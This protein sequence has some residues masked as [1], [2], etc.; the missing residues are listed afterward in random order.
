MKNALIATD[1][2]GEIF[3][4]NF[5]EAPFY[6][7]YNRDNFLKR[8]SNKNLSGI[9]LSQYILMGT[10]VSDKYREELV[11]SGVDSIVLDFKNLNS[12]RAFYLDFLE[13]V[14]VFE[15]YSSEYEFWF[16]ENKFVYLSE[17]EALKM[18]VPSEGKGLEVGVGSGRF[19]KPL[20]ILYGVEP[21][22]KMAQ[23]AR[24]R[25]IKVY[26]GLAEDL[27][28]R[29]SEFDFV[30]LA[31]TICFVNDPERSLLEAKRVLK[32]GSKLIVAIVD[33]ESELGKLYL[34]R[35]SKSVFYKNARFFSSEEVIE[36]F[37]KIGIRFLGAVQVLFEVNIKD[38]NYVQK[39]EP[40]YGR[41]A[42]VVLTGEKV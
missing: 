16:E 33:K 4:G 35:Q 9:D 36:L 7:V 20:G 34:E 38:L 28:F 29:D 1:C 23:I 21:S 8:I 11:K 6:S 2:T 39:P 40:G 15:K 42:F 19:A 18:V 31:V 30:L 12:A 32:K 10:K 22:D 25:G 41:G 27:P 13:K 37:N 26:K 24:D 5:D 17:I 3:K 14:E